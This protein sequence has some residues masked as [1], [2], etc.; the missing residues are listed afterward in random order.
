MSIQMNELREMMMQLMQ[1]NKPPSS[2]PIEVVSD[3][4]PPKVD[5]GDGFSKE[6]VAGL[7][8]NEDDTPKAKPM[9][10]ENYNTVSPSNVY[11]PDPPIP[12]PHIVYQWHPPL[13]TP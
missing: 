10:T 11:S 9:G 4:I 1:A 5:E 8:E 3:V 6:T 12:H 13:L 2:T 7:K